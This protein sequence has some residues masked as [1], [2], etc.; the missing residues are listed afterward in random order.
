MMPARM[1]CGDIEV[2]ALSDGL[3]AVDGGAMFGVVPKTDWS[4]QFPADPD[5]LIE[6]G[7]NCF[8]LKTPA[9]LVL[10][11]TGVGDKLEGPL[12]KFYTVRR[13][14][15]LIESLHALG[16]EKE[17][18]GVV[19]NTHLHFDHCGGNT[20]RAASDGYEPSFPKAEYV[21]QKGERDFALDPPPRE[22]SSYLAETFVPIDSC[23]RLRLVEGAADVRPGV[24]VFLTPGHT[25]YH[26][27]VRVESRGQVFVVLGDLVPTA[28]H[29][30]SSAVMSFD[31]YPLETMAVKD[32]LFGQGLAGS[33]T[34][35]FGHDPVHVFGRVERVGPGYRFRPVAG[36]PASK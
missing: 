10:V 31:L 29:V 24:R 7:L 12:S 15:G 1:M 11:D 26:Q 16:F 36:R 13:E 30:R 34:Y 2:I 9:E 19:I 17:D 35:G 28:A 3:L 5:N 23:G 18:I 22:R 27:S 33:W 14:H 8:L 32:D 4:R 20:A 21:V 6:I 25:R